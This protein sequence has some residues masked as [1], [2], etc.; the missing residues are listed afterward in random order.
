MCNSNNE[1]IINQYNENDNSNEIMK[2]QWK[3]NEKCV[4]KIANSSNN[5]NNMKMKT[6]MKIINNISNNN[7]M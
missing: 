6:I 5:V 2:S 3:W 7:N 1:N 4:M